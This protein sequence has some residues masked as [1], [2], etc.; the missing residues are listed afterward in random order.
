WHAS[1][2]IVELISAKYIAQPLVKITS[3]LSIS[4]NQPYGF[5]SLLNSMQ[6]SQHCSV[7]AIQFE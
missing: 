2:F 1:F 4:S 3:E 6:Q 5:V 7:A